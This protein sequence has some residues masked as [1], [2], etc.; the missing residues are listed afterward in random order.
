MPLA[1]CATPIGNLEDITLRVLDELRSADLVLCEDTRRTRILLGRHGISARL[2]SYHGHN[3]AARLDEVL[4][5]L[6]RGERL[7]L[8]SDA[9]LPGI[10]DPGALL[11]RFGSVDDS[12]APSLRL[13]GD[14]VDP[15]GIVDAVRGAGGELQELRRTLD[16]VANEKERLEREASQIEKGVV[17]ILE[18]LRRANGTGKIFFDYAPKENPIPALEPLLVEALQSSKINGPFAAPKK[19]YIVPDLPKTRS[20]KIMRRIMRKIIAG[21]GDQ[22]GDL[23]TL[24]EPGVV[25]LIKEKVS[26]S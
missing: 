7:A 1:V 10:N 15:A 8:V 26:A 4:Q 22:L 17:A 11:E 23:S 21:E 14:H 6:R 2:R 19:I 5:R 3:E 9:G 20:G 24:A 16:A 12:N 13:Y 25:D 18:R